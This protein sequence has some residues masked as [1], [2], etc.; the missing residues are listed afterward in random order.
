MIEPNNIV[1][2]NGNGKYKVIGFIEGSRTIVEIQDIERGEG[3]SDYKQ[4]YTGV[5]LYAKGRQTGWKR[6]E[7]HCYGDILKVHKKF[8]TKYE[9]NKDNGHGIQV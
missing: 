8:L 6:G 2:C 7:N 9:P 4:C 3:W 1:T 5:K